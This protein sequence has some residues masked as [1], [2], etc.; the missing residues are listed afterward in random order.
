LFVDYSAV[1]VKNLLFSG[2]KRSKNA[3]R[4]TGTPRP[5][6][7]GSVQ[8]LTILACA[9]NRACFAPCPRFAA[10]MLALPQVSS[11]TL[12][13]RCRESAMSLL[14]RA[15]CEARPKAYASQYRAIALHYLFGEGGVSPPV[16]KGVFVT[17]FAP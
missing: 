4:P 12:N 13:W 9:D 5:P 2:E 16:L 6:R 15:R 7:I 14:N 1:A 11:K 8:Q 10:L 17:F 3:F